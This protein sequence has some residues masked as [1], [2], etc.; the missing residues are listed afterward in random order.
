MKNWAPNNSHFV[1]LS[2]PADWIAKPR[3]KLLGNAEAGIAD[4]NPTMIFCQVVWLSIENLQD[5][6]KTP[7]FDLLPI[8]QFPSVC[9]SNCHLPMSVSICLLLILSFWLSFYFFVFSFQFVHYVLSYVAMLFLTIKYFKNPM[10][11]NKLIQSVQKRK[12][13]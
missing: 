5:F 6:W 13:L 3:E 4:A 10:K 1:L 12:I 7:T 2:Q 9:L 11:S 8:Y